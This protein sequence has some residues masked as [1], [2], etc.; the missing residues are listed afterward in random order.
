MGN[1]EDYPS[2]PKVVQVPYMTDC[3]VKLQQGQVAAI[4]TDNSILEGLAAQDPF[5]KIV[6]PYL[7]DE[8]YGLAISKDAPGLR[9]LRQRGPRQSERSRRRLG[10][11][12]PPLGRQPGP[13]AAPRRV[14]QLDPAERRTRNGD[15][16]RTAAMPR[17][18]LA[19]AIVPD[20]ARPAN[21]PGP[22]SG[23]AATGHDEVNVL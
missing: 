17:P 15:R 23:L 9:P 5:T 7:T 2:H 4:T 10:G 18:D 21:W 20:A 1:I 16:R 3:L 12:L 6:G 13:P 14:R 8:P 11:Q 19:R 22:A